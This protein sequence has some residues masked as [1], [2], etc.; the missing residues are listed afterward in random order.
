MSRKKSIINIL[1]Y[2]VGISIFTVIINMFLNLKVEYYLSFD[3]MKLSMIGLA[4][5]LVVINFNY[6]KNQFKENFF[7]PETY[8]YGVIGFISVVILFMIM[9]NIFLNIDPK[10]VQTPGNESEVN[11]I[12]AGVSKIQVFLVIAVLIPF[13]EEI[14]FRASIMALLIGD[15]I[16]KSYLPYILC[17]II[18]ALLHDTSILANPFSLQ[19]IYYFFIYFIPSI[20]L[21]IVFKKTNHNLLAVYV[22]HILNNSMSMF[23]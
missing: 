5:V 23:L 14:I 17:A 4:I 12:I 7:K 13:V 16:S 11:S 18:F 2:F 20:V 9:S 22:V 21:C 1:L 3:Y 8:I 15:T 19:N 6:I 10:L